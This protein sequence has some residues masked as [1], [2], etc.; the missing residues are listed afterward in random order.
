MEY[1][2][3][4]EASAKWGISTIRITILANE[5]RIPGA[6]R[7]GKSWLIP[8]GATKPTPR[9]A[10]QPKNDP[11]NFSFPMYHF[12]PDFSYIKKSELSP[13]QQRLLTAETAV[14][15]CRFEDALPLLNTILKATEDIVTEIGCLAS[16]AICCIALNKP[17]EFSKKYLKLQILFADDFPHK[18]DLLPILDFIKT[19]IETIDFMA[20]KYT[21]STDVDDQALPMVCVL[22]GYSRML[23]ETLK[24]GSTDLSLQEANLRFLK[25]TSAIITTEFIHCYL[26]GINAFR[27][28]DHE[29]KKHA[30]AVVLYAYENKL[31]FPMVTYYRYSSMFLAPVLD[32]YP[33]EFK[34]HCQELFLKYEEN[35]SNFLSSISEYAVFS[36][37]SVTDYPYSS[38]VFM[39]LSNSQIAEKLGVSKYTVKRRVSIICEKLGVGSKQELIEYLRNYA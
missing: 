38:G 9:K 19:Y 27:Q 21:C 37:L 26:L 28:N 6:K 7:L 33:K 1:I 10:R 29:A 18:K 34:N 3:T 30:E 4:K 31:Y 25:N 23:K 15:E 17:E 13:E 14:M 12:R 5:G 16:A 24:P 11:D 39:G 8:A 32:G 36:K 20:K 2:T 35:F 22:M